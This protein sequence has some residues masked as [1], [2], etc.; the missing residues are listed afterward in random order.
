[1]KEV[2]PKETKRASAFEMWM[3]SPSFS[4][5]WSYRENTERD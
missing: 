2:N 5:L 3:G 4:I 1:M